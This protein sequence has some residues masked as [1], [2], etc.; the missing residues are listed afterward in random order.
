MS[1]KPSSRKRNEV[2]YSCK[3]CD[4]PDNLA[5]V[6]CD[7]CKKWLHYECAGVTKAI[8]KSNVA[9]MCSDCDVPKQDG[10]FSGGG[11]IINSTVLNTNNDR[12]IARPEIDNDTN[13]DRDEDTVQTAGDNVLTIPEGQTRDQHTPLL[14][15]NDINQPNKNSKSKS[16]C[17]KSSKSSSR[18]L[19]NL[20]L[21]RLNEE[22]AMQQ[23][24]NIEYL[25]KK[26]KILREQ[27]DDS[28]SESDSDSISIQ[29]RNTCNKQ[30]VEA[31]AD[32]LS[33]S[34]NLMHDEMNKV[35]KFPS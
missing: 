26:Y 16:I 15:P 17:S 23:K 25:D 24:L 8:E 27:I 14:E 10:E 5:M 9:F 6:Q 7:K 28:E 32:E 11:T 4:K 21:E 35:V 20:E 22:H 12:S 18:R 29:S 1:S 13:G 3:T 30:R 34:K 33:K 2:T 31:W 19:K